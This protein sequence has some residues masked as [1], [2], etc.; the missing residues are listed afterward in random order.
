[1]HEHVP[2]FTVAESSKIDRQIDGLACRNLFLRDKKKQNYL[3]VAGNDTMIDMKKLPV[4][5]DSGR[6]SFGSAERLWQYLG[7]RP[8]SVCPFSIM[9]DK[10]GEVEI[11]L[12]QD[13]MAAE[14]V[15]Y[16]P[17]ENHFTVGLK[18]DDLLKFIRAHDHEPQIIDLKQAAPD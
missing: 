10:A 11:F 13:M 2:V 1:L 9:N 17:M 18:P 16:H 4:L 5:L 15:C 14:T 7:V 6:L 8:G 3:V 12:D